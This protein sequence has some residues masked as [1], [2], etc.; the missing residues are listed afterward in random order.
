MSTIPSGFIQFNQW[1]FG[2]GNNSLSAN[3]THM[4]GAAGTYTATLTLTSD[5]GCLDTATVSVIVNALPPSTITA[6]GPLTFCAGDSVMLSAAAGGYDYMWSTA[7]TTMSITVMA[8]GTY[9]LTISDTLTGCMAM[10]SVD[11]TVLP[12][13]TVSAGNDVTLSLGSSTELNG[14]GTNIITWSW[15]PNTGLTDPNIPNPIASPT[16]TTMYM[17]TGTDMNGCMDMDTMTV[18]VIMD[19][20]VVIA[21]LM[22][23]NDDG[24]NDRWIVQNIENY[25]DTKVII[26][27]REGQEVFS[28]DSYDNNWDGTSK[29]GKKLPDG[30]YYYVL[31]FKDDE[32]EKVYKGAITILSEASK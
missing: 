13:P 8:S 12:N 10:D 2:D 15:F 20:N 22:T 27:N 9:A 21:N 32:S 11:V 7:D 4:Y 5:R 23:P 16:V 3:P 1:D 31:M 30:T 24:Y 18:T 14:S 29:F 28:S 25:P 6:S 26:V 19:F 17:L